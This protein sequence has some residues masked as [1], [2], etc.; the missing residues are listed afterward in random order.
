M[1]SP[2]GADLQ[3]GW[4][5]RIDGDRVIQLAAQTLQSFFT[6]GGKAREHAEY[7]LDDVE[8]RPPVL[9]PP[10]V[11]DFYAFEQ[12]VKA[13]R[14]KRGL[15]VPEEWYRIP[16]FYFSNPS[17]I[18]GPESE[19]PYPDGTNELDYELELAVVIGKS[20]SHFGADEAADYIAGYTIFNDITARD[21]QRREMRSGVFSFCKA[22]DTFCPLGPWIVTPDEVG[23]PHDLD[24]KLRVNGDV[25]R[26][27]N[28]A[29]P[30][31]TATRFW[32]GEA[33]V[34]VFD[35]AGPLAVF[36][37]EER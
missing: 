2:K 19:I 17:V 18:Y 37:R 33:G 36:V 20:G 28:P 16:V 27:D 29:A 30:H 34:L 21:I 32:H 15:E 22:I 13:A 24:M 14:A 11:R 8:L 7:P 6:G 3:R 10:S 23:D 5:G 1:F 26:T 35:F 9:H 31:A 4:P 25:L 12:H